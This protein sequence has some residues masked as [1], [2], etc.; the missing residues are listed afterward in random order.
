MTRRAR[1]GL[2][3]LALVL[4]ISG[5][6]QAQ[7]QTGTISGRV[8]DF[9]LQDG[10]LGPLCKLCRNHKTVWPWGE[11]RTS[12]AVAAVEL[13]GVRA[14]ARR[15]SRKRGYRNSGYPSHDR[16]RK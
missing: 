2:A 11:T 7:V 6:A 15:L 10:R 12:A 9:D 4:G 1:L 16:M 14:T 3:L 13:T 8:T 5:E